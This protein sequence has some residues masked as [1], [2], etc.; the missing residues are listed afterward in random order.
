MYK[1]P[2]W[3]LLEILYAL[4][5]MF[6]CACTVERTCNSRIGIHKKKEFEYFSCAWCYDFLFQ[7]THKTLIASEVV[8]YLYHTIENRVILPDI[9]NQTYVNDICSTLDKDECHRWQTCCSAASACCQKQLSVPLGDLNN[10][11]DR[12]WDGWICWDD[13]HPGQQ[14]YQSCP[15]YLTFSVPSRQA[16]KTCL[17][18]ATWER[19]EG[20]EWTD[21]QT[22]LY[23]DDLK[24]SIYIGFACSLVSIAALFPAVVIFI[25]YQALRKQHRIRLHINFFLSLFLKESAVALWDMLVTYE[26]ITNSDSSSTVLAQNGAGCKILS[27]L[28]IYAKGASFTWMFCEGYYLHRLMSDAFSPPRSLIPIFVAGWAIPFVSTLIYAVLRIVYANES[29]WSTSYGHF[30]WIFDAPNLACLLVNLIFLCNILR[31]LLTQIQS[32]PNEPSHFRRAV[33]ATFVLIPLFGVQLFVTIYRIPT[34]SPG[35]LEYERFSIVTN[36]LQGFF[37]AL[38]FCFLNNEVSSHIQ[39]QRCFNKLVISNIRR[40]WRRRVR[41]RGASHSRRT[42][43]TSVNMS[44]TR[45][46]ADF[47]CVNKPLCDI[48]NENR[49]CSPDKGDNMF[50]PYDENSVKCVPKTDFSNL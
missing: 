10:T 19:R 9:N 36:N 43:M 33:K 42:D 27:F 8:H 17:S 4:Q 32:H 21:Y 37:V 49:G 11:C 44:L 29:C 20:F 15:L 23:V 3:R 18:N 5:L 24:T 7:T 35:G 1:V 38:I 28:K 25:R 45:T 2:G 26:R 46:D 30:E 31:I 12:T 34:S 41:D 6:E 22:C 13:T 16:V 14:V 40:S 47:H 39:L 50:C 48:K